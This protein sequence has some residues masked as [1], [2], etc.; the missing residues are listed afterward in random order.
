MP[1]THYLHWIDRG[2]LLQDHQTARDLLGAKEAELAAVKSQYN[3]ELN[4]IRAN[5]A[6][7]EVVDTPFTIFLV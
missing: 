3:A 7:L 1:N 5:Y 6:Q 2:C 4:N